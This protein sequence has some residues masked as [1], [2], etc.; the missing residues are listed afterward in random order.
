MRGKFS[1]APTKQLKLLH[2]NH[3]VSITNASEQ[4]GEQNIF[5]LKYQKYKK[6]LSTRSYTY[7]IYIALGL[8][9]LYRIQKTKC[10][11]I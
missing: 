11:P 8:A 4:V 6:K 10:F 5:E 9:H 7:I 3:L 1:K 2:K